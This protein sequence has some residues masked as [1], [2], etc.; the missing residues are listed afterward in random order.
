MTKLK[1]TVI[2]LAL[3]TIITA[4]YLVWRV[5]QPVE[6][7]AVHRG[8]NLL[9]K[10]YPITDKGKIDWWIKNQSALMDKYH[11]PK[12]DDYDGSFMVI[13]WDIGDGYKKMPRRDTGSELACFDDMKT[14]VNCIEKN[15]IISIDRY[16]GGKIRYT[17]KQGGT[18]LQQHEGGEIVQIK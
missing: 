5:S 10:N 3:V 6:I 8:V 9:V 2:A 15:G 4:G 14:D 12:I 1:V 18:Y 17:I 16:D 11:F 13:I 7:I